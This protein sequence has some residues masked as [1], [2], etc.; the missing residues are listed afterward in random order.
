[1][2]TGH[3]KTMTALMAALAG[4]NLIYGAGMTESGVTFDYAQYVLDNEIAAMVKRSVGGILVSDADLGV[5]DIHKVGSFGHYLGL[6][7]TR[8]RGRELSQPR[9]MDRRGREGW[10]AA[11]SVD[12]YSAAKA[13]AKRILEEHH[14]PA[15]P[16]DV[17]AE[18]QAILHEVEKQR[19]VA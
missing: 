18:V 6:P 14:P 7:S 8:K 19:G 12:A 4:A 15:L 16:S 13:E 3:E 5:D 17:A 11:G 2:Q 1:V 9:L 10:E